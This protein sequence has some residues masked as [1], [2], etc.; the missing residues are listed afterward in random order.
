[1]M[2]AFPIP[3]DAVVISDVDPSASL[4]S[5]L[6]QALQQTMADRGLKLPLG[7]ES[8]LFDDD[9]LLQLNQWTLQLAAAGFLADQIDL[10]LAPWRDEGLAPQLVVAARVDPESNLVAF[11][12][13]CTNAELQQ[14]IRGQDLSATQL[15]LDTTCFQG[16]IDR[17]F[18][19]VQ[20]LEP[21]IMPRQALRTA[22][23]RTG[24]QV[25]AISDWIQGLIDEALSSTGASL[26]PVSAGAFRAAAS[27]G[28]PDGARALLT[29]PLGLNEADEIVSGYDASLCIE[30]F[31][32]QLIP[33]GHEAIVD[34]LL[35]RLCGQVDA[36]LLPDGLVLL[37]KQGLTQQR[38]ESSDDLMLELHLNTSD[39]PIELS[40]HRGESSMFELPAITIA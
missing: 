26:Q 37:C 36:D 21:S 29:V 40:V 19:L 3:V 18:S 31:Q 16:G 27:R 25:V 17:L 34:G 30:Q 33:L 39:I 2:E 1:M 10:D 15:S 32:L 35:V 23:Q 20:L 24:Q 9:R 11:Q 22:L 4:R 13:V 8:A 14:L 12:G 38:L 28:L 6:I 5:L 7:P